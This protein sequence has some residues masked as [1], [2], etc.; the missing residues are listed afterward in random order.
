MLK[1]PNIIAT[2]NDCHRGRDIRGS[3][4]R[5][6]GASFPAGRLHARAG[7]RIP[8]H[9]PVLAF[10]RCMLPPD[11]A[12]SRS[13]G[14]LDYGA[15]MLAAFFLI[16]RVHHASSFAGFLCMALASCGGVALLFP[17]LGMRWKD[18]AWATARPQLQGGHV[19]ELALR[20][21]DHGLR[22]GLWLNGALYLPMVGSFA[23]LAQAGAF[24]ALVNSSDLSSR[25]SPR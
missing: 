22:G 2:S 19:G 24:Q 5:A 25:A 20:S 10:P 18:V 7:H 17:S 8:S 14:E 21:W 12:R 3:G 13:A 1:S 6:H 9:S 16:S 11:P 23:G 15:L 4:D